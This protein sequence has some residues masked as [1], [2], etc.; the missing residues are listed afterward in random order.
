MKKRSTL[1]ESVGKTLTYIYEA[2]DH[3]EILMVFGE[4]YVCLTVV[5][6][7]DEHEIREVSLDACQWIWDRDLIK[8]G[9]FTNDEI[10]ARNEAKE[11]QR[12]E[13]ERETY[14][15]LRKKFEGKS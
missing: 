9:I 7:Y 8:A 15:R 1:E 12:L 14:N 6:G 4:E 10:D 5:E 3:S 13:S 11:F 2:S